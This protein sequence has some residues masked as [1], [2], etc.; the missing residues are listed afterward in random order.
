M[1]C[2]RS[3]RQGFTL[4]ELLVVIAIIGVLIA[5][6]LPAV[7]AAREA[8][9]RS[10]CTNNMKQIGLALHNYHDVNGRLPHGSFH[11]DRWGW[12]PRMI[13][14]M[15]GGAEFAQYDFRIQSW[16]P[17][18][19]G[20][21]F[22]NIR[23]IHKNFLCPS[24]TL[25]ERITQEEGF[26]AGWEISQCDYAANI[27]DYMN[28]TGIGATPAYGNVGYVG[29]FPPIEVRGVI[30]RWRWAASFRDVT[31]GLS[32]TM[33]LGECIGALC[34]TQNFGTQCWAT[35]AH[36]I[37]YMNQSLIANPPTPANPRWDESIGFRSYHPGGA[38]FLLGDGSVRF[39]SETIDGVVYR[40]MASR[41][42]AETIT[43]P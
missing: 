42:G 9:R 11:A 19:N 10:Q 43:I 15:E 41:T 3:K 38:N 24:D 14:F 18:Q 5:L 25:S 31:D 33:F 39:L 27:G 8:A 28:S 21:N 36:P 1:V 37:N 32:N 23:R 30:G 34:I 4:V 17:D 7:Q 26:G 40:G 29:N 22:Q 13:A 2:F 6:L 20:A 35:T 16:Q 12:P